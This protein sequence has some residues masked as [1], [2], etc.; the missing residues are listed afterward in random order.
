M[1]LFVKFNVYNRRQK[2]PQPHAADSGIQAEVASSWLVPT[3]QIGRQRPSQT[4]SGQLTE[5]VG[6]FTVVRVVRRAQGTRSASTGLMQPS[7]NRTTQGDMVSGSGHAFIDSGHPHQP[8]GPAS[9]RENRSTRPTHPWPPSLY[10][11]K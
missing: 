10:H 9:A 3:Y 8:V 11:P 1:H 6:P 7:P 5:T 2:K 4:S